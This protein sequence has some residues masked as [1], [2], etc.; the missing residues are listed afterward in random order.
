MDFKSTYTLASTAFPG[1]I[2][3]LKRMGPKRRAE[4]ELSV[5]AAR[6]K[7]RE[8]SIRHED[9]RQKL[10]AAIALSPRDDE[11]RP[12]EAELRGETLMLAMELQAISDEAAA[13]VRAQIHPAFIAAAVKSFGG[14]EALTYDGKPASAALLVENGP[15]ELFDE[16]VASINGNGYLPAEAARNLRLPSTSGAQADGEL[17]NTIAPLAS[18]DDSILPAAA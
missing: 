1:V 16:L 15:D 17:T 18:P 8:L 10:V 7:Q 13:L 4:V 14:S 9:V 11:G 2:V 6:A 12:I 5:S 3:T